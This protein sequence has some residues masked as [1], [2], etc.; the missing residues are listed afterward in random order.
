MILDFLGF[1]FFNPDNLSGLFSTQQHQIDFLSSS[2]ARWGWEASNQV[3][4]VESQFYFERSIPATKS[5]SK[6]SRKSKAEKA[7]S[8]CRAS[9]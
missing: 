3:F 7:F 9:L 8:C 5:S 1:M 4:G 2:P 6:E